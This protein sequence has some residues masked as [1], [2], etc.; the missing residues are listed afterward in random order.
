MNSRNRENTRETASP[1]EQLAS[2]ILGRDVR[3]FIAE[4][5][6]EGR[7]WRLIAQDIAD[8]TGRRVNVTYE[9]ARQWG[10]PQRVAS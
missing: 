4:R 3:D 5:R 9:T 1:S 10:E 8:A 7:S 6:A 2:L